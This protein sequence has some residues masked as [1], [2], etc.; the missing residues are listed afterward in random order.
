MKKN[1]KL[2]IWIKIV[3]TISTIL[4][5]FN[6]TY[7]TIVKAADDSDDGVYGLIAG[8]V[9]SLTV[10]IGDGLM[11]LANKA[12][13]GEFPI[14]VLKNNIWDTIKFW[15]NI[16]LGTA[17]TVAAFVITKSP[18]ITK[19]VATAVI[20]GTGLTLI[21]E[22][23]GWIDILPKRVE[24]PSFFV[25]P[26]KIF[27]GKVPILDVDIIHPAYGDS[28][29]SNLQSVVASW[30]NTFRIIAIVGLLSVLVYIAIR[31]ILSA[32]ADDKAKYKTMLKDWVVAFCLLFFMHY[33]MSFATTMVKNITYIISVDTLFNVQDSAGTPLTTK[34]LE[35]KYKLSGT[36]EKDKFTE[37]AKYHTAGFMK[38]NY[39]IKYEGNDK[40]L[41]FNFEEF[42]R[43]QAQTTEWGTNDIGV[44]IGYTLLYSVLV[45][46]TIMFFFIYLKRLIYIIFLTMIAP[47]VALT[48]PLD[49]I[50]DG[51]AQGFNTWLKEYIFNLLI[52]PFHLI[53]YYVLIG[54]AQELVLKY[55][56]YA[57][58]V[59]GM[60]LPVEKLLRKMFGFEKASTV[61]S[62]SNGIVTGA[63]IMGGVKMLT[64]GV[65]NI[66]RGNKGSGKLNV[67]GNRSGNTGDEEDNSQAGFRGNGAFNALNFLKDNDDSSR[68]DDTNLDDTGAAMYDYINNNPV[69]EASTFTGNS[70]NF[71]PLDDTSLDSTGAAMA[72]YINNNSAEDTNLFNG[73]SIDFK[74]IDDTGLDDTGT[75]MA[76]YINNNPMN[77][78]W[79]QD[80]TNG[81]KKPKK[82]NIQKRLTGNYFEKLGQLNNL[83]ERGELNQEQFEKERKKL[84]SQFR[85]E[86]RQI[87]TQ[88]DLEEMRTNIKAMEAAADK[89]GINSESVGNLAKGAAS[90]AGGA[91]LGGTGAMVGMAAGLASDDFSNVPK[92]GISGAAAAGG[93]GYATTNKVVNMPSDIYKKLAPT[94]GKIEAAGDEYARVKYG[95]EEMQRR[96]NERLNEEHMKSKK[97]QK[98]YQDAFGREWKKAMQSSL[99]YR[100]ETGVTNNK[101][102]IN[103]MKEMKKQNKELDCKEG[104]AT[105]KLANNIKNRS[106]ISFMVEHLQRNNVDKKKI[107]R[108]EKNVLKVTGLE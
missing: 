47:L 54:S 39:D 36:D 50:K 5:L 12:V 19:I 42:I 16:A 90:L 46:Y 80:N 4:M 68:T 86:K 94:K 3:L 53:L 59:L 104:L 22:H 61:G 51:S 95:K 1:S 40:D 106:D 89:L 60:M 99:K 97:V 28:I 38:E 74:P 25:T 100:N 24:L 18:L 101:L 102:I 91:V 75:A 14:V 65:R 48:Y 37:I 17:A 96:I 49:K 85:K 73:N 13:G 84:G 69:E 6:Y 45:I 92:W 30:Y 2:N 23:A 107:D 88:R 56:I 67:S 103:T 79:Q 9:Q 76:D 81:L 26:E 32:A 10:G 105:V 41:L 58:V 98:M 55:P 8:P 35:E 93:A 31:I 63:A 78:I 7:P 82:Q 33:I 66:G 15:V 83:K 87:R 57:I 62:L 64:N 108:M 71:N 34:D 29:A 77:D 20:G 44:R 11:M 27:T 43:F 72:D 21:G 70:M 52:Q